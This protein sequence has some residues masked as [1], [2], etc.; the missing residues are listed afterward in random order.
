MTGGE[1][2]GVCQ[3]QVGEG[4]LVAGGPGEPQNGQVEVFGDGDGEG[5]ITALLLPF[6]D[7]H[8]D[9]PDDL[10]ET[11]HGV[12]VGMGEVDAPI[13]DAAEE[14]VSVCDDVAVCVD[15]EAG[16]AAADAEAT[17]DLSLVG[18]P[19]LAG[20]EIGGEAGSGGDGVD[21][22]LDADDGGA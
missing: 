7:G 10:E 13:A 22:G 3:R 1:G 2:V 18:G 6:S 16:A 8:P 21:G 9:V 20:G 15:E 5:E 14:D 4:R 11:G 12:P 17:G 19:G